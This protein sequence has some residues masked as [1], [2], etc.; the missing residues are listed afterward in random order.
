[1]GVGPHLLYDIIVWDYLRI[2]CTYVRIVEKKRK[3]RMK[4]AG[5]IKDVGETY[6]SLVS[7]HDCVYL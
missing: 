2:Y 3:N 5:A 6:E 4:K 1:M 7:L